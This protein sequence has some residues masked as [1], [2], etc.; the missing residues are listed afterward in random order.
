[1]VEIE[2]E[3]KPSCLQATIP[4]WETNPLLAASQLWE[5]GVTT[6][7]ERERERERERETAKS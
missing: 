4:S 2:F 3:S 6:L 5:M 1:M 7:V